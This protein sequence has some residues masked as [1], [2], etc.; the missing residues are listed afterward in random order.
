MRV[1]RTGAAGYPALL[2]LFEE[3]RAFE[4]PPL[5]QGAPDYSQAR[6]ER[7]LTELARLRSKLDVLD[8]SGWALPQ[9]VDARCLRAEFD[10]YELNVR[11]LRPWQRDPAFYR[12]V[13]TEESD[14]PEHEGPT[15]PAS[16]ELWQFRLPLTA[17]RAQALATALEVIPPV[18]EQAREHLTGNARDL[19]VAGTGTL[20]QQVRDL[21]SLAAQCGEASP[22]LQ[23]SIAAAR[24]ATAR[25]VDWLVA[26]TPKKTG[27][28]GIGREAYDRQL[29]HVHLVPFTWADEVALMKRELARAHASLRME[30]LRNQKLPPLPEISS[31]A[32]FDARARAA[33][34]R[35]V[36]FLDR[37][38]FMRVRDYMAP[39]LLEHTGAFAPPESRHF[40]DRVTHL[41][42][43]ALYTH[44]YHWWDHARARAEPPKT[45]MRARPLL[46]NIWDS[47]SEGM[48]TAMEEFMLH[49]GLYDEQP[50]AREIVWIMLA[51]RAARALGSLYAQANL[52]TMQEAANFHVEWTPRGWMRPDLDLLGFE[53][54]LYLRQPGYGTSYLTGKILIERLMQARAAQRGADFS[55]YDFF[56][57]F[58][59]CGLIPVSCIHLELTGRPFDFGSG[60]AHDRPIDEG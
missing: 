44:W 34:A 3:W 24:A 2:A 32:E 53:Q 21:D 27:P 19:W 43:L 54:Q 52:F 51:Q 22:A 18:L 1:D 14:T 46:Y 8:T 7:S 23:A 5:R 11:E 9:R 20:R 49:A 6:L 60:A 57:E 48:A 28:S 30:E 47:R 56:E 38:R 31:A 45:P 25:F 33:V 59:A 29:K 10:G 37:S 55:T 13:W 41:E 12:L 16:V 4:A 26:E 39:A 50:R 15:H 17:S 58:D 36:E 35:F 42:P 40:F